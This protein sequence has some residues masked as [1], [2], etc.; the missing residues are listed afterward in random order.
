MKYNNFFK[1]QNKIL[2]AFIVCEDSNFKFLTPK[3]TD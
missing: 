1:L 3:T 2:P